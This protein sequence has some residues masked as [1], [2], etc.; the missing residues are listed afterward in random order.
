MKDVIIIDNDQNDNI[1]ASVRAVNNTNS[2]TIEIILPTQDKKL[3]VD[4]HRA[5]SLPLGPIG[6]SLQNKREKR[7]NT[8]GKFMRLIYKA[9]KN[10]LRS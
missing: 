6:K 5:N 9:L 10:T 3:L 1:P 4:Q 7:R 8:N 2:S